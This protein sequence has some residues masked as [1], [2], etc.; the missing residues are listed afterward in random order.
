MNYT[1]H[2]DKLL[3]ILSLIFLLIKFSII[4]NDK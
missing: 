1:I 3:L 2:L 4:D